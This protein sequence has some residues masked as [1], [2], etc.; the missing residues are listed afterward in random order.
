MT[1]LLPVVYADYQPTVDTPGIL[2]ADFTTLITGTHHLPFTGEELSSILPPVYVE[3]TVVAL[4]C[5]VKFFGFQGT[6]L[7]LEI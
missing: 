6:V 1:M 3:D 4:K 7:V 5:A 2:L